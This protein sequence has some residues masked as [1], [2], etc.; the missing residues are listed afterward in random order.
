[1]RSIPHWHHLSH[2]RAASETER[3][4]NAPYFTLERLTTE[5]RFTAVGTLRFRRRCGKDYT[6]RV[7]LEY[8]RWY[9]K[10]PPL[11]FDHDK[12]FTPTLDGHLFTTHEICVTLTERGEFTKISEQLTHEV[13]TATL[14]WYHK[15]LIFDRTGRWPGLAEKHGLDAVIDLLIER[16]IIPDAT[17]MSNWLTQHTIANGTFRAPDIYAPCPCGSGK[18]LKFCHRDDLQPFFKRLTNLFDPKHQRTHAHG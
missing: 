16:D 6:F 17:T 8:P 12:V 1:M 14:V 2:T 3:L 11:V 5:E 9:P 13:L 7:R 18:R 4:K 10:D 15:R